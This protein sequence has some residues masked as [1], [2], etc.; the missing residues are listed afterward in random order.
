MLVKCR[1][2]N[3]K[4]ERN[5]AFKVVVSGRNHYY[6]NEE[7]YQ[8]IIKQQEQKDN[9]YNCICEIFGYK[10]TN[11]ALFKEI[12]NLLETYSYELIFEYLHKNKDYLCSVMQKE[13]VSEY[14]RIRYF[15]AIL[16]NSLVDFKMK[17]P[18]KPKIVDVE[19]D[20]P[21]INYK[22]KS[23]RKALCEIEM[24]VGDLT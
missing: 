7:E 15:S 18:S 16:K 5:D 17:E 1:C 8:S 24:E 20:M 6:C 14:A 22:R 23:K 11:T 4:I 10:I 9:T 3:K 2:C 19:V 21:V 12:N 13:F